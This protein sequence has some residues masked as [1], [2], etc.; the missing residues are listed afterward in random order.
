MARVI[1]LL[2]LFSNKC[3]LNHL[4]VCISTFWTLWAQPWCEVFLPLRLC[5]L[6]KTFLSNIALCPPA[7]RHHNCATVVGLEQLSVITGPY[8]WRLWPCA[9]TD[10]Y[11]N[12]WRVLDHPPWTPHHHAYKTKGRTHGC[13]FLESTVL[14]STVQQRCPAWAYGT[15][16][17]CGFQTPWGSRGC[18]ASNSHITED[19]AWTGNVAAVVKRAQKRLHFLSALGTTHLLQQLPRSLHCCSIENVLFHRKCA[20]LLCA[21]FYEHFIPFFFCIYWHDECMNGAHI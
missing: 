3:W 17:A 20:N 2:L 5:S 4:F 8:L 9:W 6:S 16:S 10:W 1:S 18:P 13:F 15:T 7:W 21:M 14:H 19:P 12:T 11:G